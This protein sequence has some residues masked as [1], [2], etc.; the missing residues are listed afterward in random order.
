MATLQWHMEVP[1]FW[2]SK[3]TKGRNEGRVQWNPNKSKPFLLIGH[4]LRIS[5]TVIVFIFT[6]NS[7][8]WYNRVWVWV[9]VIAIVG[10]TQISI[11]KLLNTVSRINYLI[12]LQKCQV[13]FWLSCAI[14]GELRLTIHE[15]ANERCVARTDDITRCVWIKYKIVCRLLYKP[16]CSKN[17]NKS[18]FNKF[19][20]IVYVPVSRSYTR[21][22]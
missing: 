14:N 21:G 8:F 7:L 1:I 20:N 2:H 12:D 11:K 17:S 19:V 18:I 9:S 16:I 6:C 5:N 3:C 15:E 13:R 4:S 22:D 10:A